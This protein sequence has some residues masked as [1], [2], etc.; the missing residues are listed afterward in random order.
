MADLVQLRPHERMSADECL[1]LCARESADYKDVIVIGYDSDGEL[2]IRS[3][4]ISC[5][6]AAFMLMAAL[7]KARGRG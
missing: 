4:N 6:E 7:D 1:A 5:A 3:S 2:M